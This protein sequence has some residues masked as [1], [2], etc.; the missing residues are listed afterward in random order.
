MSRSKASRAGRYVLLFSAAVHLLAV[1]LVALPGH[2]WALAIAL[3]VTNHLVLTA[4][5]LWPLSRFLGPNHPRLPPHAR[6]SGAIALTIDD[7]PDPTVTPQVLEL[8]DR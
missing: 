2:R 3:V 1:A 8:L 6:V 7:G 5:G 4:A